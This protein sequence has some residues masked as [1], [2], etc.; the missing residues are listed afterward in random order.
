[1]DDLDNRVDDLGNRVDDLDFDVKKPR[2][3]W[4]SIWMIRLEV[5][6]AKLVLVLARCAVLCCAVMVFVFISWVLSIDF[7]LCQGGQPQ[8]FAPTIISGGWRNMAKSRFKKF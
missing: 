1:M 2:I 8:G 3:K 4:L 6:R 5:V 7:G